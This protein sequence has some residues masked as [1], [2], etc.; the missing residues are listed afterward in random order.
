M[1]FLMYR[2][3]LFLIII[4]VFL[5]SA[6]NLFSR[7]EEKPVITV[8]SKAVTKEELRREIKQVTFEMGINEQE[9]KSYIEPIIDKVIVKF[10]IM[11]YGKEKGIGI[12]KEE[13]ESAING[14][15]KDYPGDVLKETLLM[16]YIDFD[17]W[18]EDLKEEILV[19]KIIREALSSTPP[20]TFDEAKAYFDSHREDFRRPSMVQLRQI[21]TRTEEEAERVLTDLKRGQDMAEEAKKYSITPEAAEGG[22]LGWIVKGELEESIEETV[23]SLPIGKISPITQSHYGFHIFNVISKRNEGMQDLPEALAEIESILMNQK[24]ES[25]FQK[26]I[27]DLRERFPVS[28]EK[29]VYTDWGEG[30]SI[31]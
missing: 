13:L 23:F 3:R 2:K 11:E 25:F 28:V 26:W 17:E 19:K 20:V 24:R 9:V 12:S 7:S 16:R 10:L 15:R 21:V 4:P 1:A 5:F 30:G 27:V 8:G 6:C 29:K 18:K 31:G 14:I 22:M